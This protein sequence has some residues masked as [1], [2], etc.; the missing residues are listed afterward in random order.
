M[1]K[2]RCL[3]V[4][5]QKS[6]I[7][8]LI[9][10]IKTRPDL[11]LVYQTENPLEV[12]ELI[13]Q[14]GIDLLFTDLHMEQM[15]G[16]QL[17]EKVIDI[18]EVICC[19][20][21]NHYGPELSE[22][23]VAYYLLKPYALESFHK[24]VDRVQMRLHTGSRSADRMK[25]DLSDT[26]RLNL[27]GKNKI[28]SLVLED[29]EYLESKGNYTLVKHTDGEDEVKYRMSELQKQLPTRYFLR[30]HKGF[31]VSIPRIFKFCSTGGIRLKGGD[32]EKCIP[33]GRTY[34]DAV[35]RVMQQQ[36]IKDLNE[37]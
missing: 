24:A 13:A 11:E 29:I 20:D 6:A 32:P 3:V 4:D 7:E 16:M 33:L 31:V 5:D 21:H 2:L 23:D 34:V 28:L 26:V 10:F 30:V 12:A 15:H 14:K 35:H 36:L 37:S 22:L 8:S 18:C 1:K 9:R 25:L 17:I 19:T 27:K